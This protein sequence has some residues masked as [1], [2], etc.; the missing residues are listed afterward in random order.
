MQCCSDS[1]STPTVQ[2]S[3]S[4]RSGRLEG[5]RRGD[6]AVFRGVPYATVNASDGRF[7]RASRVESWSGTRVAVRKGPVAP[8][9]SALPRRM[10]RYSAVPAAGWDEDCLSVDVF[11]P[12]CELHGLPVL[13]WIHGG[14]FSHGSGSFWIYDGG[15][16]AARG[17]V[18]V[19]AINYRLG[20]LGNLDLRWLDPTGSGFEANVGLRDQLDALRWVRDE[21]EAFGGDPG[22]VTVFGQ[23]AGAMSIGA[24]L[25]APEARGL[26]ERAILQSGA[27]RNVHAPDDARRVAEAFVIELG[28]DPDAGDTPARLRRTAP[29]E[30][31]R[32]Q[33]AVGARIRLPLGMLAWQPCVDGGLLGAA[34][35]EA[36]ADPSVPAVPLLIG[37]N[38]DEWKMFTATD[39][40]R[41]RLDASTLRGYVARTLGRDRVDGEVDVDEVLD[42]Y[43]SDPETGTAR[44]PADAWV[45]FQTDRVFRRPAVE[46]ADAYAARGAPTWFYR[47][48]RAPV[49]MAD[50]IG[51]CHALELPFVFGTLRSPALRLAFAWPAGAHQVSDRMQAA[52]VAFARGGD[53]NDGSGDPWPRY[54]NG[55]GRARVF[56][57]RDVEAAAATEPIRRLWSRL[58]S[59]RA[60]RR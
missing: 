8:Q 11:T 41:R 28:L 27:A 6:V 38:R 18:V 5:E 17:G 30:L 45:A 46:L 55:D 50:R 53:P 44:K 35:S 7:R 37:V 52:W 22:N 47:F 40:R 24:L 56:G 1:L 20:A 34:P 19:V 9:R 39:A 60:P 42:L 33:Q 4:I 16:L 59:V 31:L 43:T 2:N 36:I 23:S 32:A 57:G 25:D 49:V 14:G 13:V 29:A 26:F 58:G 3:T 54:R 21:I 48:D 15:R 10:H 12:G 51:A